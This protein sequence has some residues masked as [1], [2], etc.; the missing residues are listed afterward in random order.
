MTN[1][2]NWGSFITPIN[3]NAPAEKL[4][5]LW[6]TRAGIEYWFLRMSEYKSSGDRNST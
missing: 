6:A 1:T 4:Y 2:Y 5:A 3:V